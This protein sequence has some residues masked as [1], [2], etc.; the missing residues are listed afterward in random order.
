MTM[1]PYSKA[2]SNGKVHKK[3]QNDK[4]LNNNEYLPT[5]LLK[6]NCHIPDSIQAFSKENGGFW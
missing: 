2:H 3:R 6:N 4:K 5:E 1:V